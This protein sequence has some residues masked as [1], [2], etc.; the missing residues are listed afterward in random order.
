[1]I[2]GRAAASMGVAAALLGGAACVFDR[3]TLPPRTTISGETDHLVFTASIEPARPRP[4]EPAAVVADIRPKPGMHVY[5]PGD[6]Y[7]P[8]TISLAPGD[9][10]RIGTTAY[11][12]PVDY[13]FAPLKETVA[14]YDAPF[15]LALGVVFTAGTPVTL[16]G[17][18]DYQACDDEVCYLPESIPLEW[19]VPVD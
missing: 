11:P 17:T 8:V 5:A 18:L 15:R 3:D 9:R 7:Q 4:G 6:D 16:N 12:D 19:R 10:L 14:V 1:M 13:Y 2:G